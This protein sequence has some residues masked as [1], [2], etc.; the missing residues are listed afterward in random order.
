MAKAAGHR[1]CGSDSEFESRYGTVAAIC[2]HPYYSHNEHKSKTRLFS[3][4]ML[5]GGG[6]GEP[7]SWIQVNM[8]IYILLA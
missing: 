4:T 1:G 7:S 5:N 8:I 2:C 6:G 3:P